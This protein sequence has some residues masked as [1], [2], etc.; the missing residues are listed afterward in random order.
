MPLSLTAHASKTLPT[1]AACVAFILFTPPII[2]SAAEP[3]QAITVQ[4]VSASRSKWR[5]PASGKVRVLKPFSKPAKRWSAGHRGVDLATDSDNAQVQAPAAGTVVF[6][7]KVVDRTV[8]VLEHPGGLRSS[9]EPVKDPLPEGTQVSAG[10]TIATL[11]PDIHHCE[12][13]PCLHW[14]VR[15]GGDREDGSGKNAEYINPL[16]LLGRERPSIL[17]PVDGS[18]TA[19]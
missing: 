1:I 11:D 8:I 18:F 12:Q 14:G 7:G 15:R 9:F 13:G 10:Q 5:S 4:Q 6:S 17:L 2:V 16:T 3:A 19:G